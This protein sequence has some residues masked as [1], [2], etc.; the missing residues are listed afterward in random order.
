M[1]MV[2]LVLAAALALP[3]PS[4][5]VPKERHVGVKECIRLGSPRASCER[6]KG[7]DLAENCRPG[8]H[9][10]RQRACYGDAPALGIS[11]IRLV[12]HLDSEKGQHDGKAREGG[13]CGLECDWLWDTGF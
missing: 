7:L 2:K 8:Y 12:C 11:T 5:Y 1:T 4:M 6:N 13:L 9:L 3:R 10:E